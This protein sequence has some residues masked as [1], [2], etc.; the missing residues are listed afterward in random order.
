MKNMEKGFFKIFLPKNSSKR[1]KIP[2]TF[3]DNKNGKLPRKVSLRDRFGNMWPIRVAKTERDFY[4]EYGWEK[5][6]EDN[7]LEFGD[8]LVFDYEGNG[9]FDFKLFG[10]TGCEK[11]GAG[12]S[13]NDEDYMVEEEETEVEEENERETIMCNKKESRSNGRHVKKEEDDDE[14][15]EEEEGEETENARRSKHRHVE[16]EEEEEANERAGILKKKVTRPKAECKRATA[17][18]VVHDYFGTK[19]FRSGRAIQPKNPYFVTKIRAKK[20]DQ[21]YVPFDV[22]RDYK[23]ELPPSMTIR[24]STGR[25]IEAKRQNWTDGRI[26]LVGGWSNL[27]RWNQVEKDDSI[28]CEFVKGEGNKGLYLQVQVL[29]EG[30]S[31]SSN[32]K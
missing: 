2:T 11:K 27:C 4:F 29:H 30:A 17:P 15:T 18:K 23:L 5:F 12:G 26:W 31:S 14:E 8:F 3:V 6:I 9:L 19:I 16:E 20:R 21:L 22:V 1:L 13:N 25:E 24:D 7:T 28:I 10:I 32:N